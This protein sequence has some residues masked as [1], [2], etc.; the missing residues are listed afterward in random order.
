ML[1][2]E[3]KQYRLIWLFEDGAIYIGVVSNIVYRWTLIGT[4][5]GPSGNGKPIRISRHEKWKMGDNGLIVEGRGHFDEEEY[6]R[7]LQVGFD[8]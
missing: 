4:N 8:G 3:E 1:E 7:Q 6:K 2:Y 5:L